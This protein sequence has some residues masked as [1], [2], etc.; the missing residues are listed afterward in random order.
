MFFNPFHIEE[1][2]H[3]EDEYVVGESYG[4]EGCEPGFYFYLGEVLFELF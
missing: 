4:R 1:A 3:T 2:G